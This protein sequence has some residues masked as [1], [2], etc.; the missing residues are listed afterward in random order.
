MYY[1]QESQII[2]DPTYRVQT[3]LPLKTQGHITLIFEMKPKHIDK[4][5]QD[6]NWVKAMQEELDQFQKNDV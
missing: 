4:A 5:M 6:D 2:G 1:S 3:R